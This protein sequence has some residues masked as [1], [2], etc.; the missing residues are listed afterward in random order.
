MKQTATKVFVLFASKN[1]NELRW[2]AGSDREGYSALDKCYLKGEQHP[3]AIFTKEY[4]AKKFFYSCLLKT[5]S[6]YGNYKFA[7]KS[8]LGKFGGAEVRAVTDKVVLDDLRERNVP[9]NP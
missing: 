1:I 2:E 6:K 9:V 3:V 5:Q 8:L 7:K 4:K